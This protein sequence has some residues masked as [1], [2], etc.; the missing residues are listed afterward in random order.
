MLPSA[1]SS[2]KSMVD[3][4]AESCQANGMEV[5]PISTSADY[6]CAGDNSV[7]Q[8]D[9]VVVAAQE[10]FTTTG[11]HI[12]SH[13]NGP[14]VTNFASGNSSSSE[15]NGIFHQ[16]GSIR[17]ADARAGAN[18]LTLQSGQYHAYPCTTKISQIQNAKCACKGKASLRLVTI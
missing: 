11:T 7:N 4:C 8:T 6:G 12:V 2:S 14:V 5:A 1:G 16:Q 15:E 17:L 18:C 13:Q 3:A 9:A 10:V